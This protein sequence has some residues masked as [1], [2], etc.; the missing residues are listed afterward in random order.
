[1]GS[2]LALQGQG[3]RDFDAEQ[4]QNW[5]E[6]MR[7]TNL[8]A[9]LKF[10]IAIVLILAL[11]SSQASA[12]IQ[13]VGGVLPG[14][15]WGQ[16]FQ[17]YGVGNFDLLAVKITSGPGGPFEAPVF[18]AFSTAGWADQPVGVNP[19]P[20]LAIASGPSVGNLLFNIEFTGS[21]SDA[22]AFDFVAFGA[23]ETPLESA[24]AS[25]N[26]GWTITAGSWSPSRSDIAGSIVV[27]AA[28]GDVPEP[29]SA[30]VWSMLAIVFTAGW[31]RSRKRA[32]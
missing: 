8:P 18:S 24:H 23:G 7:N 12:A 29:A 20:S 3:A 32:S 11:G 1:L 30:I 2:E 5:S 14:N 9:G 10:L 4:L 16:Q 22:L 31:W 21:S 26:G 13:A 19:A 6:M 15:S 27:P 28:V 25:W 17:E